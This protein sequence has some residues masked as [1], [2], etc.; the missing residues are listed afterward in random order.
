MY[1]KVITDKNICKSC[2][3]CKNVSKC[4]NIHC[5]G[6]LA[7]CYACPYEAKKIIKDENERK[8]ITILVD[9]IQYTVPERITIKEALRLCGYEFGIYPGE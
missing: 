4:L 6:C 7:Y 9:G 8:G 1:S 3:F 5:I 2:N